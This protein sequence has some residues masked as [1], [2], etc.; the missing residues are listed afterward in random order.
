MI[1]EHVYDFGVFACVV[2]RLQD[3]ESSARKEG[4]EKFS[5]DAKMIY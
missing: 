5:H 3:Q 4:K 2:E 1:L